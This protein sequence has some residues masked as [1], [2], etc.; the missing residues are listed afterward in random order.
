MRYHIDL[1]KGIM[2]YK[3]TAIIIPA[4]NEG[5]I[6]GEV[7]KD[8]KTFFDKVIV[9]NDGSK[10][11]TSI[12]AKSAGAIVISHF[13][14]IGQ[15]GALETGIRYA[16]SLPEIKYFVTFDADGQHRLEDAIAMLDELKRGNEDIIIGSRFLIETSNIP[17]IKKTI[18]RMATVF[19]RLTIGIKIT[20]THNGLR[21]FTRNYAERLNLR[22][23]GMAHASEMLELIKKDDLRYKEMPVIINYTEYSKNKGQPVIN[24][25]NIV[26]DLIFRSK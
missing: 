25:V 13:T 19:T 12:K 5:S 15:G 17:I 1:C 20:D 18:L 24:A 6:I 2:N 11:D 22:N 21:V 8:V 14:N 10:D 7:I 3:E 23:F 26:F 9:V 4:H 16:L